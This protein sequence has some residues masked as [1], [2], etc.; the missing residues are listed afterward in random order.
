[1]SEALQEKDSLIDQY[2]AQILVLNKLMY[3]MVNMVTVKFIYL[4]GFY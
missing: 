1:M 4:K 2:N 3:E